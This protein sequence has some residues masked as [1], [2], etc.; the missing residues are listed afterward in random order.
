MASLSSYSTRPALIAIGFTTTIAQVVLMRE[1]VATFYGNELLLGIVLAVWLSWV[2]V[3]AWCLSRWQARR[4]LKLESIAVGLILAGVLL[5]VQLAL[6]R[7]TRSILG[8]TPG[9]FVE[10]G[11]MVAAILLI[12]AP[13]CLLGGCVFALGARLTVDQ[14]GTAGQAYVWESVGAIVGGALFSFA[15]IRWCDPFQTALL[16]AAVNIVVAPN[17]LLHGHYPPIP[18]LPA[19]LLAMAILG[20]VALIGGNALHRATLRWQWDRL[21]YAADS[22]YGRLTIQARNSQRIFFENGLLAFETQGTFPEEVVHFPLLA[23]P[24]PG[25][26]LLIGGGV[27][28]DLVELLK[29]PVENVTYVELDSLVIEAARAYLPAEEAA[30]L[31]DPRVTLVLEDGRLY[32]MQTAGKASTVYDVILLDLPEPS[33][34][35]LN[36]FYTQE[37]FTEVRAILKPG[38]I[39]SLG[40][41]SAENYWS[42][43][44]ARR[45]ASVYRTLLS[46]FPQVLVLPGGHNFFLA[47]DTPIQSDPNVLTSRLT[48]R[49]I[50]NSLVTPEYIR[51]LLTS[52]RFAEVRKEIEAQAGVRTNTD[53]API[54]YYYDLALW[55]SRFYPGLREVFEK[56]TLATNPVGSAWIMGGVAFFLALM[57]LVL[58]VFRQ[59]AVPVVVVGVG[60][61]QMTLEVV[62]LLAFQVLHGY[63]YAQISLI[64]AS[65]MGGLAIGGGL[66]NYLMKGRLKNPLKARRW[67][68]FTLGG[69]AIYCGFFPIL[70]TWNLPAPQVTFPLLA[71][72]AGHLTGM[73][74]PLSVALV[75]SEPGVAAGTLYGIDLVGGCL[76]ALL[77]AILLVPLLGITQTCMVIALIALAGLASMIF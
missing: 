60:L 43:E 34:G 13:L 55:M 72:I 6:I 46:V 73:V 62:I 69:I 37:F 39:L 27:S 3:G 61:T 14:G 19:S 41:P 35:A 33:T 53:L 2:A 74:Y 58:R 76:G 32:I 49:G 21:V 68:V 29:H 71:L 9:A 75:D 57:V 24:A 31:D 11:P 20:S 8:V 15:L 28:G 30:V 42:P 67:L 40:L 65:F 63:V 77:S 25:S 23:H 50:K 54:C 10:F 7:G 1:L 66:S 22:P 18:R 59:W 36:R 45:N 16:L 38:G 52:D 12:L 64:V 56:A 5:P 26:I 4:L 51:F 48:E 70:L 47:S 17:L 44:L